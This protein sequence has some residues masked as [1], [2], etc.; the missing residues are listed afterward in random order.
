MGAYAKLGNNKKY[1]FGSI[2]SDLFFY[3]KCMNLGKIKPK[4]FIFS[5]N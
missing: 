2:F 4:L 5:V 3:R 1:N